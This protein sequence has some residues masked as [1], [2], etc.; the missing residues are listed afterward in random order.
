MAEL[1]GLKIRQNE[2]FEGIQIGN[3]VLKSGKSADDLW[4]ISKYKRKSFDALIRLLDDFR[5]NTGL[6]INYNKTTILRIGS[7]RKTD[8]KFYTTLPL[9]WSDGPVK[10]LGIQFYSD[11]KLRDEVNKNHDLLPK[12]EAVYKSW[13][14]RSVNLLGKIQVINMLNGIFVHV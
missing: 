6:A 5:K 4:A 3:F 1:I 7:L 11:L 13:K 12:I 9:T 2:D 14:H 8:A 10:I